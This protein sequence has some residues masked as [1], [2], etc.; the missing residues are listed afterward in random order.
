MSKTVLITG[1]STGFG[2]D[3]VLQ[4]AK[5]QWNVVA[6]MRDVKKADAEFGQY[7]NVQVMALDITNQE[8]IQQVVNQV[9]AQYGQID[10]LFNNAGYAQAG[11]FEEVTV[12]QARR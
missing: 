4:F 6:T 8:M 9:T 11:V 1:T 2:R 7:P 5:R 10:V 3:A 12:E